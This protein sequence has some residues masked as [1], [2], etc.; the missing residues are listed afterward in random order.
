[1]P[2]V[3]HDEMLDLVHDAMLEIQSRPRG[4]K[5]DEIV[6]AV[7]EI[8]GRQSAKHWADKL[9]ADGR[10]VREPGAGGLRALADAEQ[11]AAIIRQ[12]LEDYGS[13]EEPDA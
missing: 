7:P 5:L 12:T 2:T 8:N 6:K 4:C 1:M 10:A 11:A 3:D 13:K 9:V